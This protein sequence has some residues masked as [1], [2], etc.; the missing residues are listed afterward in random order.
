MPQPLLRGEAYCSAL[1]CSSVGGRAR[2]ARTGSHM[3]T[4]CA[5][6]GVG[7]YNLCWD[8]H[9]KNNFGPGYVEVGHVLQQ[10]QLANKVSFEEV[11]SNDNN[12]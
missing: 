12:A 4:L 6:V 2:N 8:M 1:V 5:R 9:L 3:E 7:P 11:I 10:M